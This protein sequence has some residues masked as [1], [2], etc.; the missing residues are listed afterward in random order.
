MNRNHG[1]QIC[2]VGGG[3]IGLCTAARLAEEGRSVT[4][5]DK[6]KDAIGPASIGN[7]GQIIP[8][9]IEPLASPDLF[10]NLIYVLFNKNSPL[11]L[12]AGYFFKALP[13]LAKFALAMRASKYK[14]SVA[15]LT[16]INQSAFED[17][18]KFFIRA[19]IE[20][21]LKCRGLL[22]VFDSQQSLQR[23]LRRWE[24]VPKPLRGELHLMTNQKLLDRE[25]RLGDSV[26][27]GIFIEKAGSIKDIDFVLKSI[28]EYCQL[29]GVQ[30][31]A[32]SV[33]EIS[34]NSRGWD[35]YLS[36]GSCL[37]SE[38][39]VVT[40]GIWSKEILRNQGF[41]ANLEAERGY[42]L[43]VETDG[44]VLHLPVVFADYGVVATQFSSKLRIGGLDE[45]AGI[46][47]RA[48]PKIFKRLMRMADKLIPGVCW[49]N[50]HQWMGFRP[51]RPDSLPVITQIKNRKG[52][53]CASGHG[54]LGMTQ[55]VTTSNLMVDL[56]EGRDSLIDMRP[57]S[58]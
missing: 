27:G 23:G 7:A 30:Y 43:T 18:I 2:V 17:T 36:D 8:G 48:D 12:R 56:I 54:H 26:F 53:F 50:S 46:N 49:Q 1:N 57:F 42:N 24:S 52:L 31:I 15:A 33:N 16:S 14:S 55:A 22:I 20:N 39:V 38:K 10:S 47:R 6:G 21:E 28:R 32:G 9:L 25:P 13:W 45:I 3:I 35:C 41:S 40:A 51:S 44:P 4:L 37:A 29:L 19:G 5:I 58:L 11:I 34:E